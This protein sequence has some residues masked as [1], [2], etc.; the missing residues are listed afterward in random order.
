MLAL[1]FASLL[2]TAIIVQKTYTPKNNLVQTAETLEDNLHRK[3]EFV[4]GIF[5]DKARF[6]QLK[7]L[8]D[9]DQ[10]ALQTIKDFTTD[11]AT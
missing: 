11:S 3:E 4:S 2:F 10:A 6:N 1:L 5:N 9:S 7:M 8:Q